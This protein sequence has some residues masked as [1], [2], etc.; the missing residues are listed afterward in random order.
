MEQQACRS[1]DRSAHTFHIPVMGTGFTIDTLLMVAKYGISSV[2]SLVDDILVEQM[3]KH[4]CSQLGEPYDEITDASEDPRAARI[5]AYL[6]LLDK[7]IGEQVRELQSSPFEPGSEITRYYEML[8]NVPLREAYEQ[9]LNTADPEEK[10]RR[11]AELRECALPGTTDVNI[12]TKLNRPTYR[13]G[14]Q[15]PPE[16]NDA[17]SALRGYANSTVSSGIVMSAGMNQQ[18]YSYAA[19]FS[20]F[21]PTEEGVIKKKIILKVSDY[22]SAL[23]QGK[24]LAKRGL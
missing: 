3:R 21:F 6:D 5:T 17:L 20:D 10:T 23:I 4:H 24:F 14:A 8:P 11:Q 13:D 19:G 9:M 1:Q 22:R 7:T 18:L 12:M 2:I 15:R 16:Y